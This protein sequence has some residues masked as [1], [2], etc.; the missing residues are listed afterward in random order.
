MRN[1]SNYCINNYS[2]EVYKWQPVIMVGQFFN[3]LS[4]N[5]KK[6]YYCHITSK[7]QYLI[8]GMYCELNDFVNSEVLQELLQ[9]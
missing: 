3:H 2:L 5:L 6:L 8:E 1:K 4:D 9:K 7:T